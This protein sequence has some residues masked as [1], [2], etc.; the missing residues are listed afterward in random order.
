MRNCIRHGKHKRATRIKPADRRGCA[1]CGV[2]GPGGA[3][4]A[5]LSFAETHSQHKQGITTITI[6][7]NHTITK[8]QNQTDYLVPGIYVLYTGI[9]RRPIPSPIPTT[10]HAPRITNHATRKN[11][12]SRITGHGEHT[13]SSAK[14]TERIAYHKIPKSQII[15]EHNTQILFAQNRKKPASQITCRNL[16]SARASSG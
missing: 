13:S 8:S 6:S 10:N 12:K 9:A 14:H 4:G 15:Q 3:I 16:T 2:P 1:G 5:A 11:R 7:Q